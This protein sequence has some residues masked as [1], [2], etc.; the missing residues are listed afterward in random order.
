MTV[1]QATGTSDLQAREDVRVRST[2]FL[3]RLVACLIT[4]SPTGNF[5]FKLLASGFH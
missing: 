3:A 5:H 4:V 2:V 1:R